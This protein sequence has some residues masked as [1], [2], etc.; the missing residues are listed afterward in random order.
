VNVR[1]E[2][3]KHR[4][5]KQ[6]RNRKKKQIWRNWI[7]MFQYRIIKRRSQAIK[8]KME[9]YMENTRNELD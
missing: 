7:E 4:R 3:R 6:D 2:T 1:E 9:R 8:C 5:W